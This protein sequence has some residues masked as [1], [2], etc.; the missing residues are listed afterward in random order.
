MNVPALGLFSWTESFPEAKC[1]SH[2]KSCSRDVLLSSWTTELARTTRL[3][4]C[5]AMSVR[6]LRLGEMDQALSFAIT[7]FRIRKKALC[8]ASKFQPLAKRLGAQTIKFNI[9]SLTGNSCVKTAFLKYY[10]NPH[11][12]RTWWW[13]WLVLQSPRAQKTS[14]SV[15]F[16]TLPS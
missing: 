6:R 3:V 2:S 11:P 1:N 10:I 4:S 7:L 8:S 15:G 9:Y 13:L 12:V 14:R 5:L 16:G